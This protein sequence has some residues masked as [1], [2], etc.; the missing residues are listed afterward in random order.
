MTDPTLLAMQESVW[1]PAGLRCADVLPEPESAEYCAHRLTLGGR[2]AVFRVAK[3][4]PTKVGQF[5]T[6]WQRSVEGPIRPFDMHDGVELF[7]VQVAL[8]AGLGQFVFPVEALARHG[9]VSVDAKGGKRAMR[10]YAPDVLTTSAQARRTQKWQ[11]GY[12]LPHHAAVAR[13]KE[14]YS[15]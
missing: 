9:V 14:L 3:T 6:L 1:D 8:G 4:T 2:Q 15:A 10:V 5:V 13:V 7:V 11:C 12:F